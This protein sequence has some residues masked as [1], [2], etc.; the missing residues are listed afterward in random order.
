[1]SKNQFHLG[2]TKVEVV[3]SAPLMGAKE[4]IHTEKL[5]KQRKEVILLA[6][7]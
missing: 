6:L 2:N 3:R 1:M 5:W 7:A 4:K